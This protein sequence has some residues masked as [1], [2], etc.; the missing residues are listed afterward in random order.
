MTVNTGYHLEGDLGGPMNIDE[1]YRWNVPV[2]TYGFDPEFTAYFGDRGVRAIEEAISI[3]NELPPA[4]DIDLDSYP[5]C[6]SMP[7]FKAAGLGLCDLKSAALAG[8]LEQMGL[9]DPIRS[10]F[11][12]RQ[13]TVYSTFTNYFIIG[14]NFDPYS[15]ELSSVVNGASFG[16]SVAESSWMPPFFADAFEYRIDLP[17]VPVD[18]VASGGPRGGVFLTGLTRDDVGG[19]RFSL[20]RENWKVESL[21]PDVTAALGNSNEVVQVAS[22]PGVEKIEFVRMQRTEGQFLPL[23]NLFTDTFVTDQGCQQQELQ[24]VSREPDILFTAADLGMKFFFDDQYLYVATVRTWARTDTSNWQN[25]A[26]LN[27]RPSGAGPGIIRPSATITFNKMGRYSEAHLGNPQFYSF[28][29]WGSFD[30]DPD[31]IAPFPGNETATSVTVNASVIRDGAQP[32]FDWKLLIKTNAIYRIQ[33]TTNLTDWITVA[34]LTNTSEGF[35]TFR[36][37]ASDPSRSLRAVLAP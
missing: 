24:R 14:R 8:L 36:Y 1:G 35:T 34:S 18:P 4:S 27:N 3:L 23:T 15:F 31:D 25:N 2:V 29:A 20:R 5:L 19:L 32:M 11:V 13:R 7:N 37:P 9:A 17:G 22:R 12:L 10:A 21:L 16:Y 28:P 26:G 33:T 30:E 6:S